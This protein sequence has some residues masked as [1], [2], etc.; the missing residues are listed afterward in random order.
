[1]LLGVVLITMLVLKWEIPQIL[2]AVGIAAVI[3]FSFN[4]RLSRSAWLNLMVSYNPN[5]KQQNEERERKRA[6]LRAQGI[7][8]DES[9]SLTSQGHHGFESKTDFS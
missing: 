2:T 5:W 1:V 8:V 3:G 4:T 9:S 7:N 6:E